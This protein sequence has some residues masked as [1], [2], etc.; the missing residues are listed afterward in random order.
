MLMMMMIIIMIMM[1]CSETSETRGDTS[2]TSKDNVSEHITAAG[3]GASNYCR[4]SVS[5]SVARHGNS[6]EPPWLQ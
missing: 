6:D 5:G 3:M 4:T 1:E 2:S